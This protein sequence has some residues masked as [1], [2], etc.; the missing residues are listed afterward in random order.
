MEENNIQNKN[1]KLYI[2]GDYLSQP[3]RSLICFCKLN[4]IPFETKFV[5]IAIGEHMTEDY[6]KINRLGK[7]PCI[8][9]IKQNGDDFSM[10]ESCSI[11]RFLSNCYNVDEKWYPKNDIYRRTLIDQW[12]DWHH[13]NTRFSMMNHVFGNVFQKKFE[14]KGIIKKAF[15]TKDMV[16]SV[17]GF[18]NKILGERKYIVDN[19]ISI[20]DLII[21]CEMNQLYLIKFD[22]SKYENV[23]EY[24]KRM[25]SIKEIRQVNEIFEKIAKKIKLDISIS[26]AKF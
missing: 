1:S 11:L 25:N 15:D 21:V 13:L 7:I 12:M 3:F 14:E 2:Y 19:E 6:K 17:L 5:N 9:L 20:A 16:H 18:L 22:F 23:V 8:K 4:N 26:T 10:G 24:L